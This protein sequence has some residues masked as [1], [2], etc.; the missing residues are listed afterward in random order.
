MAFSVC[1]E[2]V[3]RLLTR[4]EAIVLDIKN[5]RLLS[6]LSISLLMLFTSNFEGLIKEGNKLGLDF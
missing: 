1:L 4:T 6:N 5:P 2:V 3:V